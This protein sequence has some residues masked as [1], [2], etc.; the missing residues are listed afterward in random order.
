[1][2]FQ[3][4]GLFV[5]SN[6]LVSNDLY[7]SSE[8]CDPKT[9]RKRSADGNDDIFNLNKSYF[10]NLHLCLFT[11]LYYTDVYDLNPLPAQFI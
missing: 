2:Q 7:R 8:D 10:Y 3:N 9:R 4:A 11:F 1:M 6:A 5:L